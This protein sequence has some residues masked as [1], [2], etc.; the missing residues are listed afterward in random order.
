M[1]QFLWNLEDFMVPVLDVDRLGIE[2]QNV[3]WTQL[4]FAT[5][6]EK[7]GISKQLVT[8]EYQKVIQ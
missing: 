8:R 7:L 4:L 3:E 5:S 1:A 2:R 6:L